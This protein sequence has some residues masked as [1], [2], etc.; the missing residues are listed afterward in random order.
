[1]TRVLL[2]LLVL[3]L[4][5]GCDVDA[6]FAER[7]RR[8]CGNT[9]DEKYFGSILS[10]PNDPDAG[11]HGYADFLSRHGELSLSCSETTAHEVYRMV[12]A[13]SAPT[14]VVIRAEDDGSRKVVRLLKVNADQQRVT[15]N[16]TRELSQ[17]EWTRIVGAIERLNFWNRPAYPS[18]TTFSS[19]IVVHGS[20]WILE[21][22]KARSYYALSRTSMQREREFD[23]VA[24]ALFSAARIETPGEFAPSR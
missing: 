21:S 6:P 17:T 13:P 19:R 5:V 23:A 11:T 10:R 18:P 7:V 15:A 14:T 2:T 22:R 4:F 24:H 20:A 9:A 8:N 12:Y 1:M 16:T 3:S